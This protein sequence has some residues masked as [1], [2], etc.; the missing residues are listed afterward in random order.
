MNRDIFKQFDA[1]YKNMVKGIVSPREYDFVLSKFID[2]YCKAVDKVVATKTKNNTLPLKQADIDTIIDSLLNE[3]TLQGYIDSAKKFFDNY[4]AS[5]RKDAE[6]RIQMSFWK[7]VGA[8]VLASLIYSLL[9]VLAFYL[10]RDQISL[11]LTQLMPM[12]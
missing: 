12:P 7:S 3:A 2:S 8:S 5:I 1:L 4:E 6:K 9:L 11:W 10:G